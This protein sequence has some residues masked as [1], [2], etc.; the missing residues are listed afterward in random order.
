MARASGSPTGLRGISSERSRLTTSTSRVVTSS[1]CWWCSLAGINSQ[2]ASTASESE[3]TSSSI[4]STRLAQTSARIRR[5]REARSGI[6]LKLSP[7]ASPSSRVASWGP[8]LCQATNRMAYS[9]ILHMRPSAASLSARAVLPMPPSPRRP[10]TA[11]APPRV[12]TRSTSSSSS[13][14]RPIQTWDGGAGD[15][16]GFPLR[17]TSS[18]SRCLSSPSRR[19]S[20]SVKLSFSSSKLSSSSSKLSSNWRRIEASTAATVFCIACSDWPPP[21]RA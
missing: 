8:I 17:G 16:S 1:A 20:K 13:L 10:V 18:G 6:S 21:A 15:R 4:S 7:S 5:Q 11:V 9:K 12:R 3:R 2:S 14:S 19:R